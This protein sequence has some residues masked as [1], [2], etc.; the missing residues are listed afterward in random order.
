MVLTDSLVTVT[1]FYVDLI[2]T[3]AATLGIAQLPD[4]TDYSIFY[5]DQTKIP[6]TPTV[7]VESGGKSKTL[8]GTARQVIV[9]PQVF[10]IVYYGKVQDVQVNR[11]AA[12]QLAE[13]VELLVHQHSTLGGVAIHS[14]VSQLT[15]GYRTVGGTQF[16]ASRLTVDVLSQVLLPQAAA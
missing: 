2:K 8:N 4:G 10:I 1:Q 12:D 15:S 3:N 5:G 16:R 6:V 7:C 14:I 13:A 11:K 9:R